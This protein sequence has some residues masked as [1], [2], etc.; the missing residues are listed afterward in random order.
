MQNRIYL[1]EDDHEISKQISIYL[2]KWGY[3]VKI[4]LDFSKIYCEFVDYNP[5]IVLMDVSLPSFSGY[6]WCKEIRLKSNVPIIFL[7]SFTDKMN[8]L[9]AIE[10]GADD[11]ITKPFDL[12]VLE[13]KI[14]ALLRRAYGM[15]SKK[16]TLEF[17]DVVLNTDTI[18][19]K[20][21]DS[22]LELGKNEFIILSMLMEKP[23]SV[24][25]KSDIMER[26]WNGDEFIDD[27]TL[28]VNIARLRKRLQSIGLKD[29][30]KTVKGLGYIIE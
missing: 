17:K 13:A 20:Y 14:K 19:L 25:S 7:T 16:D 30:I 12:S 2:K 6:H 10:M 23:N 22:E 24:I 3:D 26:I 15:V 11:Y 8:L 29:F 27:N 9:M 4:A 5:E 18:R 21:K 1:V 28:N